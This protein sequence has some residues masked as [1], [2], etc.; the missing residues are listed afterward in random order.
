M[1]SLPSQSNP[2]A[3]SETQRSIEAASAYLVLGMYE[4]AN[5]EVESLPI[6]WFNAR[7]VLSLRAS[8][9]S[10]LKN[11]ELLREVAALLVSSWPEES[12]HWI[13]FGFASGK[14]R[15][16]ADAEEGLLEALLLHR[17]EPAIF[18]NPSSHLA[19]C[20]C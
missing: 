20:D 10:K 7:S 3:V 17:C 8:I 12:S 9:H 2:P 15:A 11:W 19:P 18:F 14:C 1:A 5:Q 6:E 13:L 4:E 16:T